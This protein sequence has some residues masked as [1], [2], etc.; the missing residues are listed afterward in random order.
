MLKFIMYVNYKIYYSTLTI[1]KYTLYTFKFFD[2]FNENNIM[3]KI[4]YY[5]IKT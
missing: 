3:I 5:E 4:P 2:I 1:L